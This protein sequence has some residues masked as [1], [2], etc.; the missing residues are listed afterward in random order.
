MKANFYKIT[1]IFLLFTLSS[2]VFSQ[3]ILFVTNFTAE[4][5][6]PGQDSALV[7]FLEYY[8]GWSIYAIDNDKYM[9]TDPNYSSPAA[10]NGYDAIYISEVVGSN[11]VV[12]FKNAGY[13]IPCVTNEGY[14]VRSDRWGW[15]MDATEDG[16]YFIQLSGAQRNKETFKLIIHDENHFISNLYPADYEML[17]TSYPDSLA[18]KIGVTG[19]QLDVC[20]NGAVN[21]GHF[22][23]DSIAEFPSFWAIPEGSTVIHSS[24]TISSNI[25]LIGTID[26]AVGIYATEEYNKLL[27]WSLKWAMGDETVSVKSNTQN[28]DISVWPNPTNGIVNVSLTTTVAGNVTIN[29]YDI[30]GQLMQTIDS[31]YLSAGKN[32]ISIDLSDMAS[33]LYYY[34][35]IS[36]NDFFSGKIIK[37]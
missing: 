34:E 18:D 31:K 25:V 9:G 7:E 27:Y 36:E 29:I 28:N 4:G 5:N 22:G 20:I 10:Y 3:T 14:A 6:V 37:N 24:E 8:V 26:R 1:L 23:S 13:P 11:Q 33:A 35:I 32:A 16:E 17:W 21:L 15:M 19:F 12:P 2:T 30:K